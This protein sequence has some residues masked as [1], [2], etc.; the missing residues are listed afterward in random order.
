MEVVGG[1]KHQGLSLR[2]LLDL[3][4]P[5]PCDFDG[6]LNRL[7]ARVHGQRHVIAKDGPHLLGP[8]GEHIV[9]EGPR[10]QGQTAGL[11]CESL[12]QLRV[13]VAL[14]DGTVGR[15]EVDVV[16]ALRIPHVD[17]L[18]TSEHNRDGLIV[19]GS[20]LGLSSNRLLGRRGVHPG[21]VAAVG[22][23]VARRRHG[24]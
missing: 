23:R 10:A 12:Y 24:R 7:G 15:Q 1:G 22:S 8:D 9:V 6:R 3:V 4:R 11:V 13:A 5:L 17:P 21:R 2:H 19:V 18:G 14:V 16:P 20:V